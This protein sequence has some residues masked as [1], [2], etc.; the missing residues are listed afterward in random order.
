[1][2]SDQRP[3]KSCQLSCGIHDLHLVGGLEWTWIDRPYRGFDDTLREAT[4]NCVGKGSPSGAGECLR[5][6]V[7][8]S[9]TAART[10][11]RR[12]GVHTVYCSDLPVRAGPGVGAIRK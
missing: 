4:A 7:E 10:R 12:W 6:L 9:R 1:M 3:G 2:P 8:P 5:I 11:Q